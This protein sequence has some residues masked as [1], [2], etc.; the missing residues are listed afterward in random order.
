VIKPHKLVQLICKSGDFTIRV[1]GVGVPNLALEFQML[2]VFEIFLGRDIN[3]SWEQTNGPMPCIGT[4]STPTFFPLYPN[5]ANRK[6]KHKHKM[7]KTSTAFTFLAT[8]L[9]MAALLAFVAT[10]FHPGGSVSKVK[11]LLEHASK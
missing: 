4:L 7:Q 1:P 2:F 6:H 5:T 8:L 10:L 9:V 11:V 3:V